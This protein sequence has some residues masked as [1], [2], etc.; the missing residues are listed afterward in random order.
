M[1][2]TWKQWYQRR[3]REDRYMLTLVRLHGQRYTRS[4]SN[5][6]EVKATT[7]ISVKKGNR[8]VMIGDGQATIGSRVA[9]SGIKKIRR[10]RHGVLVGMAGNA[11][12]GLA[13]IETFEKY[14]EEASGNLNLACT[15]LVKNW[16]ADPFR[17]EVNVSLCVTDGKSNMVVSGSGDV[18]VSEDGIMAVGSGGYYATAAARALMDL[19]MNA[20]EI[21]RKAMYVLSPPPF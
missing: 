12:E 19:D 9:K 7:I 13:F 5:L 14:L 21:A 16:R 8:V 18:I 11:G 4:L 20:E 6:E 1:G 15:H 10:L 3:V 17:R 2:R